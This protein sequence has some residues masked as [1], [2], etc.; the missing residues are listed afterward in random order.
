MNRSAKI[1]HTMNTSS[2]SSLS[3]LRK[4]SKNYKYIS[5]DES[6]QQFYTRVDYLEQIIKERMTTKK[7]T[8]LKKLLNKVKM[9]RI[10]S[11]MNL[12]KPYR[13]RLTFQILDK[14]EKEV[15]KVLSR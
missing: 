11:Y 13:R 9:L 8:D 4:Y 5:S 10:S 6:I 12:Y 14:I 2:Q 3:Q 7:D 1:Y 15:N